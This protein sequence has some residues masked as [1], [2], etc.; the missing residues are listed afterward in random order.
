VN[1]SASTLKLAVIPAQA[2]IQV[3]LTVDFKRNQLCALDSRLRGNDDASGGGSDA[4]PQ[5]Y[6]T[7]RLVLRP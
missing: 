1:S 7:V 6:F 3:V 5:S 4:L 2:G